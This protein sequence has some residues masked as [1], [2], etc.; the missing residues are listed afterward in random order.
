MPSAFGPATVELII[1]HDTGVNATLA[2]LHGQYEAKA[3]WLHLLG[4]RPHRDGLYY[5][6]SAGAIGTLQLQQ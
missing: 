6:R 1:N 2:R 5:E 4:V 3:E